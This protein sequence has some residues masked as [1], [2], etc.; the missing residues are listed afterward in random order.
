MKCNHPRELSLEIIQAEQK[1]RRKRVARDVD[2]NITGDSAIQRRTL[3]SSYQDCGLC[4]AL[5]GEDWDQHRAV[6]AR[7]CPASDSGL[8]RALEQRA[9]QQCRRLHHAE[10]DAR[11][12]S[13]GASGQSGLEVGD[14]KREAGNRRH[15]R[16]KLASSVDLRRCRST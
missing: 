4:P 6:H 12:A 9:S 11:R 10:G 3:F 1:S 14:G 15:F 16:N 8:R 2:R 13:A 5:V 7:R